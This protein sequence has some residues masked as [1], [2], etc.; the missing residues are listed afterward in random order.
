MPKEPTQPP[1]RKLIFEHAELRNM[2][3]EN[4]ML[5]LAEMAG[6]KSSLAWDAEYLRISAQQ[7]NAVGVKK[8]TEL[9]EQEKLPVKDVTDV[10]DPNNP[11][12]MYRYFEL[13]EA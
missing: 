5:F 12:P 4:K 6:L 9:C 3:R 1:P 10:I 8:W 13:L 7:D 11:S 2:S